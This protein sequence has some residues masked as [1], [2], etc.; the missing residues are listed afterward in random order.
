LALVTVTIAIPVFEGSAVEVAKTYRVRF[1]SFGATKSDPLELMLVLL[2][3]AP[4]PD[5]FE[6]TLQVTA[7][8][9]LFVPVTKALN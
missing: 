1:H 4:V 8:L 6:L 7:L 2:A 3:T 9:G 5:A